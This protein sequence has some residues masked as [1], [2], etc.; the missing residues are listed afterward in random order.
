[1]LLIMIQCWNTKREKEEDHAVWQPQ[2]P[3]L[4]ECP[5]AQHPNGISWRAVRLGM[6]TAELFSFPVSVDDASCFY[7]RDSHLRSPSQAHPLLGWFVLWI[8]CLC[9]GPSGFGHLPL[10]SSRVSSSMS[11]DLIITHSG[12]CYHRLGWIWPPPTPSQLLLCWVRHQPPPGEFRV[13]SLSSSLFSSHVAGSFQLPEAK[14]LPT[15]FWPHSHALSSTHSTSPQPVFTKSSL[16]DHPPL[17]WVQMLDQLWVPFSSLPAHCLLGDLIHFRGF[18]YH[19]HDN[20]FQIYIFSTN[21]LKLQTHI[22]C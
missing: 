14:V 3:V 18:K 5:W 4:L 22:S 6:L 21:T 13:S 20:D 9:H 2:L 16:P 7:Q 19:L 12:F 11:A 17:L 10:L 15:R 8:S 1:M